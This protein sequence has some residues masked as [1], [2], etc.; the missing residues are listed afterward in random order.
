MIGTWT[1]PFSDGGAVEEMLVAIDRDRTRRV[2]VIPALFD[3]ANKLRR[4]TVETM[5]QLDELGVDSFLPDFPGQNE[6]LAPLENQT[7]AGWQA[8][9]R[10]AASFTRATHVLALR[11]GALLAPEDLPGWLYAPQPGAKQ[12]RAMIRARTIAA[13]EAGRDENSETLYAIGRENGL[14]LAGWS[15]GAEMV[16]ELEESREIDSGATQAIAQSDLGGAG[17]WLRAEPG[18]A[19]DQSERLAQ[20]IASNA[21]VSQ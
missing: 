12:M 18:A 3:E 11:A 21:G 20:I 2:L 1:V 13:R 9:A 16:S 6:S 15:I 17:L 8:A 7:L 5:R 14:D 19:P 10:A 4:F